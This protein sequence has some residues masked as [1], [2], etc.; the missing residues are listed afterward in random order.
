MRQE[1]TTLIVNK[2]GMGN[3]E[4][5]LSL[6][7]IKNFLTLT[8]EDGSYPT[9]ICFYAEGVK[10]TTEGSPVIEELREIEKSGCKLLV[11]KTCLTYYNLLDKVEAGTVATMV[12]IM[13]AQQ[14]SNKVIT[15]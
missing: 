12:D 11:C 4:S 13:G 14:N 9:Y 6:K 8:I 7:L 2:N 1:K 10:L 15:L 5:E 3:A